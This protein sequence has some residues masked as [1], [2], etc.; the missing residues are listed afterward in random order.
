MVIGLFII[1]GLHGATRHQTIGVWL[2][3]H[4]GTQTFIGSMRSMS[5]PSCVGAVNVLFV[6]TALVGGIIYY[7][8]YRMNIRIVL[9]QSALH[10]ANGV[11][12]LKKH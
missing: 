5:T 7:P 6:A 12:E 1:H 2:P 4:P 10:K 8:A 3:G 9:E 11:F